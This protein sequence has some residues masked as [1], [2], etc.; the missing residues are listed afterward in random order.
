MIQEQIDEINDSLDSATDSLFDSPQEA[1]ASIS[2]VL[3]SYGIVMPVITDYCDDL[4]FRLISDEIGNCL[5][6]YIT[7]DFIDDKYEVYATIA[8]EN[9]L[10]L[11]DSFIDNDEDDLKEPE[12]EDV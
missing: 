1:I 5:Y 6:L 12:T 11:L 7:L 9:E 3:E 4:V 8:N 2:M 10:N